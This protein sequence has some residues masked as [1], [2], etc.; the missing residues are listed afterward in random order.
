MDNRE[1]FRQAKIA[2]A[3]R[4]REEALNELA[5]LTGRNRLAGARRRLAMAEQKIIEYQDVEK[6]WADPLRRWTFEQFELGG[7]NVSSVSAA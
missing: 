4:L 5:T 7:C 3:K 2:A 1:I 6:F